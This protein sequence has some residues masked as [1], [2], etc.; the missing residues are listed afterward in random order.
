MMLLVLNAINIFGL[1]RSDSHK[2]FPVF[3]NLQ[4]NYLLDLPKLLC[5]IQGI[6]VCSFTSRREHTFLSIQ[7]LLWLSRFTSASS[8]IGVSTVSSGE[9]VRFTGDLVC[10]VVI[11]YCS[12]IDAVKLVFLLL[13][14]FQQF[15]KFYAM[16]SISVHLFCLDPLILK[17]Q[18]VHLLL[19]AVRS[20]ST[21]VFKYQLETS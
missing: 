16:Q 3:H 9:H 21:I 13:A 15:M 6:R 7:R 4:P 19:V 12:L 14:L 2:I 1:F 8:R 20:K 18:L 17:K 10:C 11:G 5:K